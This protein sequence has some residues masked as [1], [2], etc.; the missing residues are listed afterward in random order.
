MSVTPRTV[1]KRSRS[2][3][4]ETPRPD[5]KSTKMAANTGTVSDELRIQILSIA[6]SVKSIK[7]G[8][9]GLKRTLESKIDRLRNDVLSTIDE[10]VRALKSDIDLDIG[11]NSRRIDELVNSVHSLTMRIGQI[12]AGADQGDGVF[13]DGRDT[14]MGWSR[15]TPAIPLD[16]NDITV[17]VKNL[18]ETPEENLLAKAREL[19]SALGED[20]SSNVRIAAVSR[21][22]ARFRNKPGLMKVSFEDVDQ[23][24]LVLRNKYKLK[25]DA[26]YKRVYI[27]S[28]K[29]HVERLLEINA[30]T[31][32]REL[33]QG[34]S[35]R[36]SGN[37]RI[38]RRQAAE[39][40]E[41]PENG[42]MD[43]QQPQA[44]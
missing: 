3:E 25:N 5:S 20:V 12:E 22:P 21:L 40:T 9:D 35:Y 24:I 42:N 1:H 34:R 28:A 2:S 41:N 23:K 11:R 15:G 7:E 39:A 17:V 33:P 29:S 19:I 30:R 44:D 36:V 18:P 14:A 10:K 43:T 37:G 8:Q 26:A 4:G 6:E 32:L 27:E 31:M 13:N 16:N 38:L